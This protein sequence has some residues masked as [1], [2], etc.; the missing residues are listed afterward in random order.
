MT[1]INLRNCL[2]LCPLKYVLEQKLQILYSERQEVLKVVVVVAVVV[3][4]V[5]GARKRMKK[6]KGVKERERREN[7]YNMFRPGIRQLSPSNNCL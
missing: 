5:V 7:E 2:L 3:V 6:Q 1:L 4:V